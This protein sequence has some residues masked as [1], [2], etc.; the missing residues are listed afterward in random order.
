[1]GGNLDV[2]SHGL[3]A[4]NVNWQSISEIEA[5]L[6]VRAQIRYGKRLAD[7]TVYPAEDGMVK[8]IF[9]EEQRAVTPGQ[10]IVFYADDIL[11]GGGIIECPLKD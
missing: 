9:E 5:P 7:C 11:L 1:M 2:F 4:C 10:S 8:V 3:L 6:E